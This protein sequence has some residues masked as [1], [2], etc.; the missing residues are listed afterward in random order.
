VPRPDVRPGAGYVHTNRGR[1]R[2]EDWNVARLFMTAARFLRDNAR[3]SNFFLW[4]DCFDPHE[5]RDSPPEFVRRYDT[6]PGYDG[7]LDPRSFGQ[8]RNAPTLSSR[9]VEHLKAQYAAKV[10]FMDKWLGR[11]LDT[12]DETGLAERTAVVLPADHGTKAPNRAAW[13]DRPGRRRIGPGVEAARLG[14]SQSAEHVRSR[15]RDRAQ[16]VST[17]RESPRCSP[18]RGRTA[19]DDA[20]YR[21]SDRWHG[22]GRAGVGVRRP[23]RPGGCRW[24]G[25]PPPRQ[26]RDLGLA[27]P[28]LQ[29]EPRLRPAD[30]A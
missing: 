2:E 25:S 30:G 18:A 14:W 24:R 13:P 4:I 11:F 16:E 5:P 23:V 7:L 22:T 9:A 8:A 10:T 28:R 27:R 21:D 12:L 26:A 20:P 1:S 29:L 3:R 6:T 17:H 19:V 15:A